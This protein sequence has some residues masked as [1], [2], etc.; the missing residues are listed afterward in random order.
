M[1][2]LFL[3]AYQQIPFVLNLVGNLKLQSL[4]AYCIA[5]LGLFY[6]LLPS[7]FICSIL[8][9]ALSSHFESFAFVDWIV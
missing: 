2:S 8:L 1:W 9:P 6:L 3:A 4:I 7:I 5:T